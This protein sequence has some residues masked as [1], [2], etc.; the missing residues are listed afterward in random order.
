MNS[1]LKVHFVGTHG[2]PARYGG[3]ETLA[4]FLA[5][6]LSNDMDLTIYCSGK[7]YKKKYEK[8]YNASLI[9]IPIPA[10]GFKGIIYD[11]VSL[12]KALSKAD[13]IVFLG[14][15][16]SGFLT[17]MNFFF[18]KRLIV[19]HGGLNEWE[20]EKLSVFQRKYAKFNHRIAAHR[21]SVNI[22]DNELYRKS[23]L[24][25]FHT[26]S[27]VIRYG[28]DHVLKIT[29]E[30]K[31][32]LLQKFPFVKGKYAVS[33]SRAQI[34]NNLHL[35]LE[36]FEHFSEYKLVLISNWNIS[37]YGKDLFIKYKDNP[38]MILLD[39]I[40]DKD[41]LDFIRGNAY[42]YIHTHSRCGTAPSLVEAMNL[43]RAIV[44]YDVPTN[45]ETTQDQAFFFSD[46][47]SLVKILEELDE[48]KI[49]S[50]E[51]QMLKIA[52]ENY[53]WDIVAAQYARIIRERE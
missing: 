5:Q 3:F 34:D 10:S 29:P 26:N 20:R 4:D 46:R 23:L 22:V 1:K 31:K 19:N 43:G 6:H 28:G 21:A 16:G 25:N 33:V 12:Y 40:Y 47:E 27:I 32:D 39:A 13:V 41:T 17:F 18:K 48:E 14:P 30:E 50:N 45:R 35:L 2:V 49:K 52:S 11:L 51:K 37:N 44:S 9:Y 7:V 24:K 53:T 42:I 15:V 8:Y 38:N 36:T